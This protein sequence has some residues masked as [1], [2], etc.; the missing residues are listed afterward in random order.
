M[1]KNTLIGILVGLLVLVGG[2]AIWEGTSKQTSAVLPQSEQTTIASQNQSAG[3]TVSPTTS[4]NPASSY[5]SKTSDP[6]V[7]TYTS[8]TLGVTF[9]YALFD[10]TDP[11]PQSSQENQVV[12]NGNTISTLTGGSIKVF[13]KDPSL[14]LA[15]A[16]ALNVPDCKIETSTVTG[17][18]LMDHA[19]IVFP[20]LQSIPYPGAAAVENTVVSNYMGDPTLTAKDQ[21][22]LKEATAT[23]DPLYFAADNTHP[24]S[25]IGVEESTQAVDAV[26][27]FNKT[28]RMVTS[29]MSSVQFLPVT[30]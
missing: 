6:N 8:P 11:Q 1:N 18:S 23:Y 7:D 16:V 27:Y 2:Y 3:N 21:A 30:S 20:D 10:P 28:T 14:S 25:Y 17:Q 5:V 15:Q 12:E 26:L 29:W 9:K 22:C 13:S 19:Q 24:G 4:T